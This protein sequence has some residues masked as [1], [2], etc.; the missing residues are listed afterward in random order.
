MRAKKFFHSSSCALVIELFSV[1]LILAFYF[2]A[3]APPLHQ[4]FARVSSTVTPLVFYF[5][6]TGPAV[7]EK[8][9]SL[10]R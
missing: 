7:A 5:L 8:K 9:T 4:Y 3:F 6:Y 10:N 2:R 1:A